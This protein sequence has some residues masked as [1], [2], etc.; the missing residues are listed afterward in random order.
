MSDV[1]RENM[2]ILVPT[3]MAAHMVQ[4]AAKAKRG[5]M[6]RVESKMVSPAGSLR[7]G[8]IRCMR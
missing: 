6:L 7:E 3:I 5:T 1:M 4:N 8:R 2:F